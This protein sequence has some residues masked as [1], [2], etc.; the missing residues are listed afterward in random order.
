[1]FVYVRNFNFW[2]YAA[3]HALKINFYRKGVL[4]LIFNRC[5]LQNLPQQLLKVQQQPYHPLASL[6][7]QQYLNVPKISEKSEK[8]KN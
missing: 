8:N 1:M 4:S 7:Y 5:K 6:E 2:I 3:T